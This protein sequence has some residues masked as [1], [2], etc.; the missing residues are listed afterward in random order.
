MKALL[1]IL[2]LLVIC[3]GCSAKPAK[4][5][6]PQSA[7]SNILTALPVGWSVSS[8]SEEQQRLTT[9]YFA[10]PAT[11]AFMLL[12]PG[13]NYIDWTYKQ[14][15]AHREYLAKECLCIWI[16]PSGVT[17]PFPHWW[18]DPPPLPERVCSPRDVQV[19]GYVSHHIADTNRL[20]RIIKMATE[21][22]S[23][24]VRLSWTTWH[25]DFSATLKN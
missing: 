11:E 19:Y 23:P 24:N 17:P 1:Q 2:T 22:S 4:I 16:V 12:G 21:I 13:S 15:A 9:A 6:H 25:E 5:F 10:H 20:E 7:R 3:A 8:P 18:T 14:G